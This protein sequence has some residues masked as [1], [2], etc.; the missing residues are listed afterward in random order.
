VQ[1]L[2]SRF[3]RQADN[4]IP[5]KATENYYNAVA[6]ISPDVRSFYRYFEVPGLGHCFGGVSSQPTQLFSQL[7]HWVEN[8][9]APEVSAIKLNATDGTEHSRILCS[10]PK[11]AKF[12]SGCGNP[13]SARC[14][15][16]AV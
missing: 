5:P 11:Q 15:S 7:R 8:G 16:C 14:W 13:A 2:T 3:T 1:S 12:D 9:T 10:Y 4:I 6:D